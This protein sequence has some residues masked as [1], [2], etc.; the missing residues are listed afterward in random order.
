M[1]ETKRQRGTVLVVI[2]V[3]FLAVSLVWGVFSQRAAD[4][5]LEQFENRAHAAFDGTDA[6]DVEALA[7][8][9]VDDWDA[10]GPSAFLTFVSQPGEPTRTTTS[11]PYR[12]TYRLDGGWGP[13]QIVTVEWTATGFEITSE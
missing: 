5:R 8:S 12:A 4:R 7:P 6:T 3:A 1:L 10:T 11:P 9:I 13:S 2:L